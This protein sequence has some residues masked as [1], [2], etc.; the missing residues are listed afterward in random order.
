MTVSRQGPA[1][2]KTEA[3]GEKRRSVRVS[4]M[5]SKRSEAGNS[6]LVE[7]EFVFVSNRLKRA[8]P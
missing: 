1:A 8:L 6:T 3:E 4:S 5:L 2:T 7:S